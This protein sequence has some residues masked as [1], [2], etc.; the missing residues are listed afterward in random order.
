MEVSW[1]QLEN[2]D[3]RESEWKY[4]AEYMEA[5]GSFHGTYSWKAAIDGRNGSFYFHRQYKLSWLPW[6][7]LL[8]LMEANLLPPTCKEVSMEVNLLPWNFYL[9]M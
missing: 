7:F 2:C 9:Y 1:K 5:D 6:K 4:V 8:T 3:I